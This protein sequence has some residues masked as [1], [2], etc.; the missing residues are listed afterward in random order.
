MSE[1]KK[2]WI[3]ETRSLPEAYLKATS[4]GGTWLDVSPTA[5]GGIAIVEMK[6]SSE[7]S[8]PEELVSVHPSALKALFS[9]AEPLPETHDGILILEVASLKAMIPYLNRAIEA[10]HHI[11]EVRI[12][13]TGTS[14]AVAFISGSLGQ[15]EVFAKQFPADF[16]HSTLELKGE[17]RRHF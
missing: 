13:R 4:V 11:V 14:G 2:I 9:L 8:E 16:K 7:A 6:T 10:Q 12:K 3:F 5:Q 15:L 1:M 17:V